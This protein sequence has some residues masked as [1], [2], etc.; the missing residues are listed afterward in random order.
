MVS[1]S[2][3]LTVKA[4]LNAGTI[5]GGTSVC[6]G[7]TLNLTASGNSGGTWSS[8]DDLIATVNPNTGVVT[9]LQQEVL[10]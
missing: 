8:S 10:P 6:A 5:S 7:A 4:V 2:A 3:T 1:T 9:G